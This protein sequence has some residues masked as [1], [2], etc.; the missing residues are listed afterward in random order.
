MDVKTCKQCGELKPITRY[1]KY[2]GGRRGTYKV[3]LDCERINSREKYLSSKETRTTEEEAELAKIHA[4]YDCQVKVGLQPPVKQGRRK[5]L[6]E[7]LN[8]MIKKYAAM[9][10]AVAQD[11]P[12]AETVVDAAPYELTRWLTEPLDKEPDYY[13]D[14][15]YEN[16]KDTYRP[17][18]G[19]NKS[20]MMPEYDNTYKDV[21]DR[22]LDRFNDYED[23]YYEGDE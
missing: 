9:S 5:P 14:E 13:L 1:R 16:L 22:I 10:A 4:L 18:T 15:V 19:I 8:D 3:C 12:K 23:S 17:C 2:Y 21:L 20:T 11:T 6:T 7:D